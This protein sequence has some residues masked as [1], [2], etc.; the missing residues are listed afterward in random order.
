MCQV[1]WLILRRDPKAGREKEILD[2]EVSKLHLAFG[3][4]RTKLSR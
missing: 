4:E 1:I 3:L 2:R